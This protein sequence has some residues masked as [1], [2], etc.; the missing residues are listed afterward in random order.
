MSEQAQGYIWPAMG[1]LQAEFDVNGLKW[2]LFSNK[3]EDLIGG[4]RLFAT[5]HFPSP[6]TLSQCV[7]FKAVSDGTVLEINWDT[8]VRL[9]AEFPN[10]GLPGVVDAIGHW[11]PNFG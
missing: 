5:L 8:G 4:E 6:D 3:G 7:E 1:G 10:G 9:T 11:R 2:E